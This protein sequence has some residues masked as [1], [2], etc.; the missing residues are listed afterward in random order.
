MGG[1]IMNSSQD[2]FYHFILDRTTPE[3][4]DDMKHLLAELIERQATGEL[5]KVYLMGVMP[6][7]LSYLKPEAVNE[8]KN[9]ISD[10]SSML[11]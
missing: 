7:A 3:H 5:N 4:Q 10:F 1:I 8:V 9:M 6:R 2:K 11:K